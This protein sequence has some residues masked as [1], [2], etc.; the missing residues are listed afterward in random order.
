MLDGSNSMSSSRAE[1]T[2][3]SPWRKREN[4]RWSRCHSRLRLAGGTSLCQSQTLHVLRNGFEIEQ[5]QM[6]FLFQFE[7]NKYCLFLLW[8]LQHILTCYL[9]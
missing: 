3:V 4:S 8:I 2:T 7:R 6:K 1:A 9:F 5:N